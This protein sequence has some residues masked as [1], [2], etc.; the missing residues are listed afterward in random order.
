MV[1]TYRTNHIQSK[2]LSIMISIANI[3]HTNSTNCCSSSR[4]QLIW[5]YIEIV[6]LNSQFECINT[7]FD[8]FDIHTHTKPQ[9]EDIRYSG[10]M[11]CSLCHVLLLFSRRVFCCISLN[12][13]VCQNFSPHSALSRLTFK[14]IIFYIL[15]FRF[16][17]QL[18]NAKCVCLFV[19]I[20]SNEYISVLEV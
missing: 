8:Q 5:G 1:R 13:C 17:K 4:F 6:Q 14:R 12:V 11:A 18:L 19:R 16:K 10:T 15:I 7:F 9:K 20:E 3:L 2:R